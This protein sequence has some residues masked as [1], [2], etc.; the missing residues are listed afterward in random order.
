MIKSQALLTGQLKKNLN[1]INSYLKS[2]YGKELETV[3][4]F[5]SQARQEAEKDSD[6]D[7]LIVLKTKFN[8]YEEIK[9]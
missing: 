6:I 8:Y 9:K 7:I 3:I 4:L 5:G 1:K 2:L